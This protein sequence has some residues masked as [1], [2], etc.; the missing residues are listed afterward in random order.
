MIDVFLEQVAYKGLQ[1]KTVMIGLGLFDHNEMIDEYLKS[2][3]HQV[4]VYQADSTAAS[5]DA[6]LPP[7]FSTEGMKAKMILLGTEEWPPKEEGEG[8]A[9]S[10]QAEETAPI[11]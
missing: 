1:V 11:S 2:K 4:F 3:G 10:A 9:G 6:G 7:R 5:E 8:S